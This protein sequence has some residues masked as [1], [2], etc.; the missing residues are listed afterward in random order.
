MAFKPYA[1]RRI[2]AKCPNFRGLVDSNFS[3][4]PFWILDLFFLAKKVSGLAEKISVPP[5]RKVSRS[6]KIVFDSTFQAK[7]PYYR[8]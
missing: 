6:P 2:L 5:S 8:I 7:L 3:W 1:S 4:T